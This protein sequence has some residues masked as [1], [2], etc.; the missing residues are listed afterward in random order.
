[1]EKD[2]IS[3]SIRSRLE[4]NLELRKGNLVTKNARSG[5]KEFVTGI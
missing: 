4:R 3:E 5:M 2:E 1:M